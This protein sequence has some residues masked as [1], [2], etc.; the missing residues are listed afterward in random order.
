VYRYDP[1]K[2]KIIAAEISFSVA[3]KESNSK[4]IKN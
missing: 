4:N 3:T 1:N 2:A